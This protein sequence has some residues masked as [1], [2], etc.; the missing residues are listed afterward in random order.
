[1]R[2]KFY[3]GEFW[4]IFNKSIA[5]FG[6]F[7]DFNNSYRFTNTFS[8]Y[9]NKLILES[10][11]KAL[12][13]T[14]KLINERIIYPKT[15]SICKIL[16]YCIMPDHYHFLLKILEDNSLSQLINNIENSFTRYFNIK[17]NRKGPLWQSAFKSVEIKSN[18]QLLH[19][20]R[21]IHLNPT[22]N[23]LV[24]TPEDWLLSSYKDFVSDKNLL[25]SF[26]KEISID[27][28]GDYKKFVENNIEYQRELKHIKKLILE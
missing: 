4:H 27:N 17:F 7:S 9:N 23:R 12:K 2:N 1:M 11:S 26:M 16:S 6:I 25:N 15:N 3:E 8:Y 18:T 28:I 24:N 21:Y 22:T 5:N 14:S 13:K 10:Y 20:S 19:V